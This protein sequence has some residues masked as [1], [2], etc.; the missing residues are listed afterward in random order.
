MLVSSVCPEQQTR[1]ATQGERQDAPNIMWTGCQHAHYWA[2]LSLNTN[3]VFVVCVRLAPHPRGYKSNNMPARAFKAARLQ[4]NRQHLSSPSS[5][6]AACEERRSTL[7]I[8]MNA[9]APQRQQ[10][11]ATDLCQMLERCKLTADSWLYIC[12]LHDVLF[13]SHSA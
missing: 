9:M 2:A 11:A 4:R 3:A 1:C 8:C 13:L 5:C 6:A 10:G 7:S 12:I